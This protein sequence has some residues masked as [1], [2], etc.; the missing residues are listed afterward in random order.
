MPRSMTGFGRNQS[1]SASASVTWEVRSV[2]SRYLDLKWRLPAFLRSREPELEKTVRKHADRGRLE[3]TCNF[4]PRQADLMD[5][6]LNLP[7]AESMLRSLDELARR[8]GHDFTPEYTRLLSIGCLW[9]ESGAEADPDLFAFLKQGLDDAM[10]DLRASRLRE[11]DLLARDI[12]GRL[13]K[14]E[15]WRAEIFRMAPQVKE[16]KFQALRTRLSSVLEKLGVEPSEERVL[17][18]VAVLSDKLD[19]SEE[20]TRLGCHLERIGQLL[21]EPSDVGKRLDFLLQETFREINT[22]GNKAQNIEVSRMVVDFKAE[23]EKCREQAQ[24]IE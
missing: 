18:E 10:A 6:G 1:E 23:L 17:Q 7:L 24:N 11:G 3:I 8:R 22:L 21:A 2:N 12:S 4:Q 20:L 13:A 15:A 16:D 19:I 14:L 5:V 9:Q